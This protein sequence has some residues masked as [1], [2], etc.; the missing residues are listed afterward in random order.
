[1]KGRRPSPIDTS[2]YRGRIAARIRGERVARKLR[3][4]VAAARAKVPTATWYNWETGRRLPIA[5]LP[6]VAAALGCRVA[7]LLPARAEPKRSLTDN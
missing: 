4:K 6:R 1:M 2:S 7:D 3:V 5:A